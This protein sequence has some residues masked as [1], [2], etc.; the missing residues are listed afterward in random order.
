MTTTV[1][2]PVTASRNN[3]SRTNGGSGGGGLNLRKMDLS[4]LQPLSPLARQASDLRRARDEAT[5]SIHRFAAFPS[6]TFIPSYLHSHIAI[7]ASFDSPLLSPFSES[8]ISQGEN[9]SRV[10][11][12]W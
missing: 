12:G 6:L 9:C 10:I 1:R 2:A 8:P 7:V 5:S 4:M 11:K 3:E